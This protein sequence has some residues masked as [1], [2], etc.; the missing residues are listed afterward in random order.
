MSS[1]YI[2]RAP[3][4]ATEA[5]HAAESLVPVSRW[6][7]PGLRPG[8]WV[9]GGPPNRLSFLQSF[10]WEPLP[11]NIRAPFSSGEGFLVPRQ[12]VTWPRGPF[13][14]IKGLYGQRKYTP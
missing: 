6:G 2:F 4:E 10:K 5:G 9:V 7:K 1:R 11:T 3:V 8:D 13:G 14:W 12:S